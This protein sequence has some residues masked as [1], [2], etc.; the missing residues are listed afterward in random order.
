MFLAEPGNSVHMLH[1][2]VTFFG[3]C[4]PHVHVRGGVGG[5]GGDSCRVVTPK[6]KCKA[7]GV[8][9]SP[10]EVF[11]NAAAAIPETRSGRIHQWGGGSS[12][13]CRKWYHLTQSFQDFCM[14]YPE[15]SALFSVVLV[16]PRWADIPG[17]SRCDMRLGPPSRQ[18]G[19]HRN[20]RSRY[21]E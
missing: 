18:H 14:M 11:M 6:S 5:V 15:I 20:F 2:H 9:V 12:P 3:H 4:Q 17:H 1:I 8:V 10:K 7:S 21:S 13:H 19:W 16:F